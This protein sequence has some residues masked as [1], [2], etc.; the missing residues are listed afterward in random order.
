MHLRDCPKPPKHLTFDPSGSFIAVSCTDGVVYI[1]SLSTATPELVNKF[2]GLIR[3]LDTEAEASSRAVWHPDGRAFAVPTATR[4]IQVLSRSDGEKQRAFSGGHNADITSLAWSPNGALLITSGADRKIVLWE[5]KTQKALA[6]YNYPNVINFVWHP[7][8]NIVSFTTSDG[9][10]FICADFVPDEFVSL[11]QGPQ[12][13]T[14]FIHDPL[15]GSNGN[16]RIPVN[17]QKQLAE[18]ARRRGTPDSLND[19][20]GSVGG[21]D[22]DDF[23]ID[24]DGAGYALNENG[25]RTNLHLG[26]D[27]EIHDAKRFG[28]A[29]QPQ[30]HES[31]QSGSTPWRGN[32][33]YLCESFFL[34]DSTAH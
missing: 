19:A 12:V 29:P 8:Q 20:M 3:P 26:L 32:R 11:L 28:Y 25:K 33:R 31:F 5:T 13:P 10:V 7:T 16:S 17:G 23:V 22:E 34:R 2:D 27:P 14:P 24:D 6:T 30:V 4:D 18:R 9:E 15:S 1:Y 21:G